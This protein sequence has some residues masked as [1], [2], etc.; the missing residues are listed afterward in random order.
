M[1]ALIKRH[2]DL[3]NQTTLD[4]KRQIMTQLP[5]E[6]RLIGIKGARG[7]G[8]TTLML[9]YIKQNYS[10]SLKAIYISLDNLYFSENKLIDFVEDFVAR[11]GE[12]L[13]VDEVHKYRNWAIEIKNIYD[14]FPKLKVVFT[15]SSML[16]ILNSR[17]DLSRRALVYNMQ[18]LSFREFLNFYHK[19]NFNVIKLEDLLTNH[20][21]IALQ[22]GKQLKPLQFFNEYLK[23]GYFPFYSGS[24]VLYYKR[25]QEIINMILEIEL[26]LLRNTDVSI[27]G[28]IKQ[29]LYVISQSVPFKPNISALADKI[30]TTRK[31]VLE[32][33]NYM[34]EA[35]VF[36]I[37]HKDAFGISLLQ[38]PEKL[39]LE[40]T[41]YMFAIIHSEPNVGSL[42]ETFFMNQLSESHTLTYS[43]KADFLVDNKYTF[44]I[45]GKDKTKKQ[46]EHI[47]NAF[48]AAD[49]IEFGYENKIPL[50]LF[51]FLY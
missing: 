28:K 45:G 12:H 22:I 11:G 41:N 49:N 29:M 39:Y 18:G 6:E 27:V 17:V 43:E 9:Q 40:N 7:V 31:T 34:K 14:S 32:Y 42:R 1:E 16:E 23:V 19:T 3:V 51:G 8:K 21:E 48:I 30:N 50:W 10:L 36:N 20:T 13:F 44:E 2:L 37:V 33:I 24:E 5:W 35:K 4:F 46:I 25:L 26:P 47:E 38:K 15:G